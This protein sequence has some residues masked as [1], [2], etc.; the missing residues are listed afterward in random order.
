[1]RFKE[2]LASVLTKEEL[3]V[4]PTGFDVIGDIA[5]IEVPQELEHKQR[6]IG[7]VL[8][9]LVKHV[10][11][12][13]KKHGIHSGVY[14][15]QKYRIIAGE[16]RKSTVHTESGVRLKI[17]IE[18]T[19]YSPRSATER[20][21]IAGLVGNG[22]RVLVLFSG[23]APF[24]LV[25]ARNAQPAKVV[26]VELN[27]FAHD[28]AVQNVMLN[29]LGKVIEL[30][31][32]DV[33]EVIPALE[34]K[35]DRIIMPLPKDA[36]LFLG[37]ALKAAKKGTMIHLY[38]FGR[39]SEIPELVAR[40]EGTCKSFKRSARVVRVVKAG[41]YAPYVFRLCLDLEVQD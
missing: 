29:K 11:V 27:P 33:R 35:F 4:C 24:P 28:F 15:L 22:E 34:G 20:L 38:E 9:D 2:A 39:E 21:R 32:G 30:V 6:K 16:R 36:E 25:I 13:V 37:D 1:M 3:A 19:Y 8:L 7:Q 26:G 14:R 23:I 10:K 41:E 12:V 17:H 5:I 18:R 31:Q 40:A